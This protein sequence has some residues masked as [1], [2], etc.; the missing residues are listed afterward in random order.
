MNV[1]FCEYIIK[2]KLKLVEICL[3][4]FNY[5]LIEIVD[6]FSFIDVSYF[7]KIFKCY[8]GMFI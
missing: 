7:F 3:F 8:I 4:N 1:L 6:E 2:V 5:I